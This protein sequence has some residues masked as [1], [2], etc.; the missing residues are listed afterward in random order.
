MREL[1]QPKKID[2][3]IKEYIYLSSFV[4]IYAFFVS[5]LF[6]KWVVPV[7]GYTGFSININYQNLF[8]SIIYINHNNVN[9]Y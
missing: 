3:I 2:K 5:F 8:L 4:L 1:I 6:L 7:Y 9:Y